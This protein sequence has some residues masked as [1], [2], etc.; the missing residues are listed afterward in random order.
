MRAKDAGKQGQGRKPTARKTAGGKP[1]KTAKPVPLARIARRKVV[2]PPLSLRKPT[3]AAGET[4]VVTRTFT[5]LVRDPEVRAAGKALALFYADVEHRLYARMAR[6]LRRTG[7]LPG[8]DSLKAEFCRTCGLASRQYNAVAGHLSGRLR[9]V[10]ANLEYRRGQVAERIVRTETTIATLT[11]DR[12]CLRRGDKPLRSRSRK[13][14]TLKKLKIPATK[15]SGL[16][17]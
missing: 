6:D 14:A 3:I 9:N 2:R 1:P 16:S 8:V 7:T 17:A 13:P 12:D 5:A 10:V 15:A 11:A 4:E